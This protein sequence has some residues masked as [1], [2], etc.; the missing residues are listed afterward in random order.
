[1]SQAPCAIG[2]GASESP[3]P[4]HLPLQWGFRD[5]KCPAL[6]VEMAVMEDRGDTPYRTDHPTSQGWHHLHPCD[7]L[8]EGPPSTCCQHPSMS[9]LP[10]PHLGPHVRS[11][12]LVCGQPSGH[13]GREG[14][15]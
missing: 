2:L 9:N 10:P 8:L 3:F 4:G 12:Q 15:L 7:L 5:P 6:Y 13:E 1:M 14:T 11:G